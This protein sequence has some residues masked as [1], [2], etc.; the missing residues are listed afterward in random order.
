MVFATWYVP[1]TVVDTAPDDGK[2]INRQ[3]RRRKEE[4]ELTQV[5]IL[6][7]RTL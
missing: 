4:V 1:N 2:H 7:L 3:K 6:R 5:M